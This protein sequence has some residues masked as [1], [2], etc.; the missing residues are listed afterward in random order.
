MKYKGVKILVKEV[1][2]GFDYIA[3]NYGNV[4]FFYINKLYSRK[5]KSKILHKILKMYF[6]KNIKRK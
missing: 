1:G 5:E 4:L 6:K 3:F 2:Y